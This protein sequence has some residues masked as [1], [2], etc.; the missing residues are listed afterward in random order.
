MHLEAAQGW[1]ELGNHEEANEE[2][3]L[4]DAPLRSHP[5]VLEV[6][7]GIYAKVKNW[8]ACLMTRPSAFLTLRLVLRSTMPL[9]ISPLLILIRISL[10][11]FIQ[12]FHALGRLR[13]HMGPNPVGISLLILLRFR[14]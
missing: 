5:D 8:E 2:L 11:L 6:R 4:I 9:L 1:L 13:Q 3:E 14:S 10:A 12:F 7:W